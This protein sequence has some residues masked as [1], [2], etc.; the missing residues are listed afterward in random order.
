MA[1]STRRRRAASTVLLRWGVLKALVN[2]DTSPPCG[3][4]ASP[5]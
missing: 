2:A 1:S 3:Q 4:G 5:G